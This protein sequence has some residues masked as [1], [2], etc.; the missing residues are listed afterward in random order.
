MAHIKTI[1]EVTFDEDGYEKKDLY[2]LLHFG[3]KYDLI[4]G[5]SGYMIPVQYSVAICQHLKTGQIETF[6]PEQLRVEG[7]EIK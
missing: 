1:V 6:M 4:P 7:N 5:E 2:Y 3:M